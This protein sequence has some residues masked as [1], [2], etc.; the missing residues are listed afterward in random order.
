MATQ[1]NDFVEIEF[2]GIIKDSNEI[3]DTTNELD[4]KKAN[5][6]IKD[7]KPFI[8]SIGNK[9][10]PLGFDN[11]LIGKEIGLNYTLLL[12]PSDA[13]GLRNPKLV[14]MVP[15]K[16]FHEQKINPVRGMQLSLDGQLVRIISN[17][18]GRT[19]IDFNNP[20]AGKEII[21]NYKILRNITDNKE[22]INGLSEFLFR[23]TFDF[24]I[25]ENKIFFTVEKQFEPFIKMFSVKFKELINLD[26]EVIIRENNKEK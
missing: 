15:T 5:L 13:F 23:R 22:K 12:K 18:S 2:T 9:M 17:S 3:F 25:K 24:E 1:K 11:D 14:R 21:Y 10:L 8:L 4:A 6:N 7:I 20:L 26:V 19:L 16:L